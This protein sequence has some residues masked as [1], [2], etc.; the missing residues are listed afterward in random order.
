MP[1]VEVMYATP[2][3]QRG[4]AVDLPEGGTVR[5]AIERSGVLRECPQIDLDRDRVGVHGRLAALEDVLREGDRVEILRPL[6][7]DPKAARRRR[8]QRERRRL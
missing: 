2:A 3:V 5:D 7:A 1:R 4:Y 8:A 6:V